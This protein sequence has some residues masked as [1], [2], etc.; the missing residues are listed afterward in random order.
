MK[1]AI[2]SV[3][4]VR[5]LWRALYSV[6]IISALTAP[7]CQAHQIVLEWNRDPVSPA[8][9]DF[10]PLCASID[11]TPEGRLICSGYQILPGDPIRL[12]PALFW[13]GML[14]SDMDSV[15]HT[16]T[17]GDTLHADVAKRVLY[18][19]GGSIIMGDRMPIKDRIAESVDSAKLTLLYL[20]ENGDSLDFLEFSNSIPTSREAFVNED[21]SVDMFA[22]KSDGP[23]VN[24]YK[25]GADRR[26][27]TKREYEYIDQGRLQHANSWRKLRN[28]DYLLTG[29]IETERFYGERRHVGVAG[30]IWRMNE[31]G[32]TVWMDVRL[33]SLFWRPPNL[34][35]FNVQGVMNNTVEHSSGCIYTTGF[36]DSYDDAGWFQAL[37]L[38]KLGQN[39]EIIWER[40]YDDNY[41][42]FDSQFQQIFE[43]R[44]DLLAIF[45]HIKYNPNRNNDQRQEGLYVALM[46]TAGEILTESFIRGARIDEYS[47]FTRVLQIES[48]R[49]IARTVGQIRTVS[50]RFDLDSVSAVE[51]DPYSPPNEFV[52]KGAFPNPFNSST[53]INFDLP[54]QTKVCITI[55][56]LSG[57]EVAT[58]ADTEMHPGTQSVRWDAGEFAAGIYFVRLETPECTKVSKMTLVK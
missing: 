37:R 12:R 17:F 33:D 48:T 24:F 43:I 8:Q 28:D 22:E 46:D 45:G 50:I 27:I 47:D 54:Q 7:P 30:Y 19:P 14:N 40:C 56:D 55:H 42:F 35:V 18:Y 16:I 23:T 25:I 21:G 26:T 10:K 38:L 51:P 3:C 36:T 20:D 11:L 29:S 41:E 31:N 34:Y 32:E 49:F 1:P 53:V 13:L 44:P 4:S 2:N 5:A 52:L 15:E 6:L 9:G 57:R 58:L 39:G